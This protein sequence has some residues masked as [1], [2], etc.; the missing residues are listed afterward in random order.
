MHKLLKLFIAALIMGSFISCKQNT[1]TLTTEQAATVKDSVLQLAAITAK[2]VSTRGPIAWLDHFENSPH[3]F[4]AN[5]GFLALPDY[6]TAESFV[7]ET[8]MKQLRSINLH[9]SAIRVEPLTP[10]FAIMAAN[11]HEDITDNNNKTTVYEGYLTATVQH[12]ANGWKFL[13]MSW[14]GKLGR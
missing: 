1:T 12:T 3:F 10:E 8:L 11:Y 2:D 4:M 5:D 6:K 9:W 13:N 7:K 14:S